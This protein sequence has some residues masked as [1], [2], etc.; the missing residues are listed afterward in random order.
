ME[1]ENSATSGGGGSSGGGGDIRVTPGAT[2]TPDHLQQDQ[3]NS[4]L[5]PTALFSG[6]LQ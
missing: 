5:D 2:S 6:K 3:A 4:L 1:K